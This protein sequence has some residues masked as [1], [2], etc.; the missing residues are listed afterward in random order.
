MPG[1]IVI[2]NGAPRSGK[3]SIAAAIQASFEGAWMNL[4]VDVLTQ[5]TPPQFRPGIGLRPGGERPDLEPFIQISYAALYE[6]I[7]A[8]SRLDLNVVADLG[9]YDLDILRDCAHRLEGLPMLFVGVRCPVEVIMARRNAGTTG[10][11]VTGT[12][13]DPVPLPVRRWQE[14]VHR[15]GIYDLEVDTSEM[16]PA[17][18]AE[19]IALRLQEGIPQPSA[20]HRLQTQLPAL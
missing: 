13:E 5:A 18:C 11:Y 16:S 15:H 1:Q 3:S 2:L 10:S 14:A 9:H 17:E 6:S 4:G 8:H 12:P 20:F 7:A 19:A